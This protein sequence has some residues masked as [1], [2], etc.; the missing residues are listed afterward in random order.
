MNTIGHNIKLTF[1][2]ES[3]AESIGIVIDNLPPGITIDEK[4]LATE[5]ERRRP[6]GII[7]TQRQEPDAYDIISGYYNSRTT[8]GPLTVLIHNRQQRPEDYEQMNN[9]PRPGHADYP[10]YIKYHGYNDPRG[11]GFFSGRMTALWMVA[12]SI[13]KQILTNHGIHAISHILSLKDIKDDSL[14]KCNIDDE[15]LKTLESG[16]F[17]VIDQSKAAMMRKLIEDAGAKGDSVGGVIESAITG[18]PA[19]LGEPMF[20]SIESY[21]S[22]LL[23]SVPGVKGIEFGSGFDITRKFGSEAN[24]CYVFD[25][26]RIK[27]STNNNGGIL[28]G[29]TTGMPV[30]LRTAIKPTSSI[31]KHQDSVDLRTMQPVDLQV[32]GRHDPAIVHRALPVINAVLYY[33]FLDFLEFGHIHDWM[34]P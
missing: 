6:K 15:L 28:G 2:G 3:H 34:K 18:L 19:G 11:G 5:L 29:I 23:F 24:D 8:G 31:S 27:T 30:I 7:S 13:A 17:P 14:D 21:L 22:Q 10:A 4:L 25:K 1:F 12:G 20:L 9:I 16:D 26:G 32:K 33:A